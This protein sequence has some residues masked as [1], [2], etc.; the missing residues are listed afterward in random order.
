MISGA[1]TKI[2][3][4]EP[5]QKR[6]RVAYKAAWYVANKEKVAAYMV[7]Y[8][9]VNR[10]KYA[11]W[12]A[13]NRD[14]R[15]AY[16]TANKDKR[17]AYQAAYSVANRV[18]IHAAQNANNRNKKLALID[19]MGGKCKDC[20]GTFIPSVYD[21]HHVDPAIKDAN[22]SILFKKG[23][24]AK[25]IEELKKCVMLCANCHRI[26]HATLDM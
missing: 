6:N 17:A 8:N 3:S 21:F 24:T 1:V 18:K 23:L 15:A 10:D 2:L 5:S 14:K 20:L 25:V 22:A 26:R 19:H 13:A 4:T 7:A 9:A 11:A 12:Y 16:Q